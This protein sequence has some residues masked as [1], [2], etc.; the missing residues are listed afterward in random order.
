MGRNCFR[1]QQVQRI[2]SDAHKSLLDSVAVL[3]MRGFRD[4]ESFSLLNLLVGDMES[5]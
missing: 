5:L 2:F 4:C 3:E 1:V